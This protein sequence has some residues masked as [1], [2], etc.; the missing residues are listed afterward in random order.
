MNG[1]VFSSKKKK[2]KKLFICHVIFHVENK[3]FLTAKF[4]IFY[5]NLNKKF[6]NIPKRG[7]QNIFDEA[8]HIILKEKTSLYF[9]LKIIIFKGGYYLYF[10]HS[11]FAV[12]YHSLMYNHSLFFITNCEH[13]IL[14]LST[15]DDFYG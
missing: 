7:D 14:D 5:I 12:I 15:V 11:I 3:T 1:D 2:P 4:S 13:G 9:S 6:K 8:L 10:T